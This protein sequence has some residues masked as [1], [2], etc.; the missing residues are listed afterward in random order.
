[1]RAM[2]IFAGLFCFAFFVS[3]SQSRAE[4]VPTDP[5][6]LSAALGSFMDVIGGS[7][8][9]KSEPG[10]RVISIVIDR[11]TVNGELSTLQRLG[12]INPDM[13]QTYFRAHENL[14]SFVVSLQASTMAVIAEYRAEKTDRSLVNV[15]FLV[16]DDYGQKQKQQA[17]S[18]TFDRALFNRINWDNFDNSNLPKVAHEFQYSPWARA[19][20]M[21]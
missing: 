4:S 8:E 21:N 13:N 7:T 6:T 15:F 12:L 3:A 1:M 16:P 9:T 5:E 10:Q 2:H 20:F 18:F 14:L 17:Y 19:N 11:N